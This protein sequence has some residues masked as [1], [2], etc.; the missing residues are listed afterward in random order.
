MTSATTTFSQ[1]F[2]LSYYVSKHYLP[3]VAMATMYEIQE[4]AII[5]SPRAK[6]YTT[7]D[8]A[9]TQFPKRKSALRANLLAAKP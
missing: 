2:R 4:P 8:M 6:V 5:F 1:L 7:Q 3:T 9:R